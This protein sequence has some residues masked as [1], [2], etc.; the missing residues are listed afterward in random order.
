MAISTIPFSEEERSA[1]EKQP[2]SGKLPR[3]PIEFA[4]P[5]VIVLQ[6]PPW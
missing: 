3:A 5:V 6:R 1:L 2:C 4:M